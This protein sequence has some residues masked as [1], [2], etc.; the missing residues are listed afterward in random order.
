MHLLTKDERKNLVSTRI[1]A[2]LDT[3]GAASLVHSRYLRDIKPCTEWNMREATLQGI[4]G[5][6]KPVTKAGI[7]HIQKPNGAVLRLK[8][9]MFDEPVGRA[10]EMVLLS[11]KAVLNC[12]FDIRYHA[13]KSAEGIVA[14]AKFYDEN[15]PSRAKAT[16]RMSNHRAATT[17]RAH[18]VF[19][20]K[21]KQGATIP[22]DIVRASKIYKTIVK[23]MILAT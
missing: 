18:A 15:M 20:A 5:K 1:E 19:M 12:E 10:H 9:Y 4:G 16:K 3:C 22:R 11:M 7:L 6:T 17:A 14:N 13:R 2:K 21:L 8:C 23:T